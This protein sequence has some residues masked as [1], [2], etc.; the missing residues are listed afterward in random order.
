MN[1]EATPVSESRSSVE[2]AENAK[3]EPIVKVK[4]YAATTDIDA[5][6]AAADM[7]IKTYH[8]VKANVA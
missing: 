4:C 8:D 1:D 2:I 7:A 5:I 3:R 6:T